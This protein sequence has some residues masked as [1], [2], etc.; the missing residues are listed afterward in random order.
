MILKPSRTSVKERGK[1]KI[2]PFAAFEVILIIDSQCSVG[3]YGFLS[4]GEVLEVL[5][6]FALFYSIPQGLA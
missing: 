5:K 1:V 4:S 6:V 3:L 2:L